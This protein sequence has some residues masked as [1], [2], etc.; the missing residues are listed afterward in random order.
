[1]MQC[2]KKVNNDESVGVVVKKNQKIYLLYAIVLTALSLYSMV[3]WKFRSDVSSLK[4]KKKDDSELEW[5]R[6]RNYLEL[7]IEPVK[8]SALIVPKDISEQKELRNVTVFVMSAPNNLEV[9]NAIRETWGPLIKP[10]FMIG[11][12]DKVSFRSLRNEA[13]TYNDLIVE[14]FVD[15][16]SNLTL[17]TALAMKNFLRY[18]ENSTYFMK[19]DDDVFLNVK[20][21]QKSFANFS[22]NQLYGKNYRN[23]I[24]FR[25]KNGK[26]Y[27]PSFL[28]AEDHYPDYFPGS[29]YM[30]PG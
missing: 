27:V 22:Q 4:H 2:T 5:L 8:D 7:F 21:L 26:Y 23:T 9:R 25:E 11:L 18:F 20:Q 24:V 6:N 17:K 19:L 30:I 13:K 3:M 16:Y 28:Y 1:M 10:I 15:S 14:N 29:C 12:S